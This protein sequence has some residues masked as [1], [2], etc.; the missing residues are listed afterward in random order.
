MALGRFTSEEPDTFQGFAPQIAVYL[1]DYQDTGNQVRIFTVNAPTD[2]VPRFLTTSGIFLSGTESWFGNS[3]PNRGGSFL[4]AGDLQGR[5][6]VLGRPDVARISN[7]FQVNTII[8]TPPMHTAYVRGLG[9]S[10]S[11]INN[12]SVTPSSFYTGFTAGTGTTTSSTSKQLAGWT[13]SYEISGELDLRFKIPLIIG[14][15]FE[16]AFSY[17]KAVECNLEQLNSS[18]TNFTD[19]ISGQTGF[20]DTVIYTES[21]QNVYFYPVIG[22]TVCPLELPDCDAFEMEPL[23]YQISAPDQVSTVIVTGTT[24]EFY[25]PVHQPGNIM[26]YPPTRTQLLSRFNSTQ[27]S[28]LS[29]PTLGFLTNNTTFTQ[30]KNWEQ[31]QGNQCTSS[32]SRTNTYN[33]SGS[34]SAGFGIIDQF[35]DIVQGG[36]KL[37]LD[38][39]YVQ[40]DSI[41]NN[42]TSSTTTTDSMGIQVVKPNE[43][44]DPVAYQYLVNSYIFGREFPEE[45]VWQ[46]LFNDGQPAANITSTGPTI[47]AFTSNMLSNDS[48]AWWESRE[49]NPYGNYPDIGLNFPTRWREVS[50]RTSGVVTPDCRLN[51][52]SSAQST[53]TWIRKAPEIP[54]ELWA[55]GFYHLRGFFIQAGKELD[56]GLIAAPA[57]TIVYI[58]DDINLSTRI[59]NLSLKEF[60]STDVIKVQFYRQEWDNTLNTPIG[61]SI[62]IEEQSISPIPPYTD[63]DIPNWNIVSTS[64]NTREAD[65]GPGKYWVFWVLVYPVDQNG[66][67]VQELPGYGFDPSE[68]QP[69]SVFSSILD[70]PLQKVNVREFVTQ[71]ERSFT[72][73]VGFYK[74]A[75]YVAPTPNNLGDEIEPTVFIDNVSVA[76]SEVVVGEEVVVKADVYSMDAAADGVT[77]V[78]HDRD[79]EEAEIAY[80]IEVLSYIEKDGL[81]NVQVTFQPEFCGEHELHISAADNGIGNEGTD[82][83]SAILNVICQPGD[84]NLDGQLIGENGKPVGTGGNGNC[85][86]ARAGTRAEV[87]LFL[88]VPLLFVAI[89]FGYRRINQ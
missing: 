21:R 39:D 5:S 40:S 6:L 29:E 19:T 45:G 15:Q 1:A 18:Y 10:E 66:D 71:V 59:Y 69:G 17:N 34:L 44:L 33:P 76:P 2:L 89:R 35:K 81:H 60:E 80:D 46:A 56:P 43:F 86:L 26:T 41:G 50:I 61:D 63:S 57:Q 88:I 22:Q 23:Y 47:V 48:G 38:F 75:V 3:N 11:E 62:L 85:S 65:M 87:P 78:F 14:L 53:C 83:V 64:I 16:G 70:V 36:G 79:P 32:T 31:G 24:S 82:I 77:V 13:M 72:N 68:F 28:I 74:M 58:G 51:D 84:T 52:F 67:L 55:N 49:V 12:F 20:A 73:N 7:W 4:K 25:Q 27:P 54:G 30:F 8:G 37:T 42:L 9:Q